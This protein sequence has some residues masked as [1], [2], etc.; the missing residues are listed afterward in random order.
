MMKKWIALLTCLVLTLA[1]VPTVAFAG[2]ADT[3][4]AA[5]NIVMPS[6]NGK[7]NGGSYVLGAGT[8]AEVTVYRDWRST[9]MNPTQSLS[10]KYVMVHNTGTYVGTATAK[11]VHNNTNKTSTSAC[12]HYT[13]DN[14]SIYQGLADNR[15]GWHAATSYSA[16]PSNINA[17]GI[18]TCVNNFPATE[19]FGG[20]KWTDGTAIMNWYKKQ[21]DQTM[22]HTAYLCL[23]LC[24]RW[25]LNWK[26]DI[27]MHYDAYQYDT[28]TKKGKDCPMQMRATY[29]ASTNTFTAAGYYKD[30]RDG[31]LWQ[32]FWGYVE[33]YANGAKSV[34]DGASIA[35]KV[36]TY[37]VQSSDGL[38]VRDGATT[39]GTTVLGALENG[40]VVQV[41]EMNGNWGKVSSSSGL[42]GWA[43]IGNYGD[44][45][46]VDAQA[47]NTTT[48]TVGLEYSF[49]N[50]GSIVVNNTS[51]ERGM[52]DLQ[53]PHQIGTATTPY[54]SLQITKNSGEGYFFGITQA[55]SGY[56]MMRDCNSGDQLV[57]EDNA[58][59]MVNTEQMEIDL[60]EWWTTKDWRIDNVRIYVAPNTSITI[61]YFYF[62]A[63]SRKV[64]DMRYNLRA[65]ASN[66]N[67]MKPDALR[68]VDTT[69]T[70]SY[71]YNNGMLTIVSEEANGY[72][73]AIDVNQEFTVEELTRFLY[74]AD[75][76]VRYDIEMVLTTS[77]GDR[78]V[79]LVNDFWPGLCTALDGD[80][81]PAAE[82]S[83][84][85][86]LK[87][88]FTYNN[89]MPA[90]GKSTIKTITIQVGGA[91]TVIVNALQIAANDRLLNFPDG[92]KQ[93]GSSPVT[94][95]I[96]PD[97]PEEPTQEI[98]DVNNDGEITTADAR[99]AM[100]EALKSGMLSAEQMPF[101]DFNGD[102]E[103]TTTDAR[104]MM[105]HALTH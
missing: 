13:V 3:A 17:I 49:N 1:L 102:G 98:G 40:E 93:T 31:Y 47:Y 39:S 88:V 29:N 46:G 45:I 25:G 6:D 41:S 7:T 43:S 67:L 24:E 81:L 36:G 69:K 33:A 19:T 103:I 26:T 80:Y 56:W 63:T 90:D 15:R 48:D 104:L 11:N 73:V 97:P 72:D 83:A 2:I 38:N 76:K 51:S 92:I 53:L 89:V 75:A 44:Y 28:A 99:M 105:L 74:S 95:P 96:E 10:P 59:Y 30:G 94:N 32:I 23:V 64:I 14:V 79:S 78:T 22:K 65:A 42:E 58:P 87:S 18:E 37:Q 68:I 52:L 16:Y 70:G 4:D 60:R 101:A 50:D 21:F 34:G 5:A 82:Q 61:N 84:G 12:W 77:E 57:Q 85:L 100:L 55:G 86:D 27:K 91:G 20:E 9:S 71:T 66:V 54:M 8:D 62:A 35:D